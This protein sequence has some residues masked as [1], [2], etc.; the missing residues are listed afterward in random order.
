MSVTLD[1]A[2]S[3]ATMQ[4]DAASAP[5]ND[6]GQETFMQLLVT[7]LQNQDPLNPQS[8]EEFV[9]QLAQFSS[10]EQLVSVNDS[11]DG[12]YLA[13]ASMNNATMTQL[14]GREVTAY[15]EQ[16]YHDG[17]SDELTVHYE[18]VGDAASAE[19][20]VK[21]EDG[22]VVYSGPMGALN[23][24]EGSFSFPAKDQDGNPL[25]EGIYSFTISATN[26]SGEDV[27]VSGMV[28]GEIDGMSYASGTPVPSIQGIEIDLGEILR[29]GVSDD[30]DGES[31]D[32]ERSE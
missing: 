27:M 32:N 4:Q 3:L 25:P 18:A 15:A 26:A 13:T 6:L 9:A 11:I 8:N 7:Q 23:D 19:I 22:E 24:G 12:L 28:Q 2:A 30:G 31:K 16:T 14:L 21:N 5:T 17:A 20:T 1:G 10:L 29:V